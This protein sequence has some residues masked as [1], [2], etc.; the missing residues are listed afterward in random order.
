LR[1]VIRH[2]KDNKGAQ[3][4]ALRVLGSFSLPQK[5]L[6]HPP[7]PFLGVIKIL[8]PVVVLLPGFETNIMTHLFGYTPAMDHPSSTFQSSFQQVTPVM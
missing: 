1:H 7:V 6:F 2:Y 3:Q 8:L 5:F 4:R